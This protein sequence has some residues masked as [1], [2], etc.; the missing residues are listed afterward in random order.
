MTFDYVIEADKEY[1]LTFDYYGATSAPG[2]YGVPFSATT[3]AKAYDAVKS[4]PADYTTLNGSL[5]NKTS[6]TNNAC[7]ILNGNDLLENGGQYLALFHIF[8]EGTELQLKN[9]KISEFTMPSDVLM[10]SYLHN[11][12]MGAEDGDLIFTSGTWNAGS[13]TFDYQIEEGYDYYLSFQFKGHNYAAAQHPSASTVATATTNLNGTVSSAI[14]LGV[15]SS[16]TAWSSVFVPLDGDALL[17]SGGTY[18]AINWV[19]VDPA[20]NYKNFKIAK[21]AKSDNIIPSALKNNEMFFGMEGNRV[22]WYCDV[23]GESYKN[24]TFSTNFE[25]EAG[26]KYAVNFDYKYTGS[27]AGGMWFGSTDTTTASS[28]SLITQIQSVNLSSA[29]DWTN[30]TVF[31]DTT[32]TDLITDTSKYFAFRAYSSWGAPK[33]YFSNLTITE[34]DADSIYPIAGDKFASQMVDGEVVTTYSA[35]T[36][37]DQYDTVGF[38]TDYVLENN[39][40][41]IVAFDYKYNG[42]WFNDSFRAISTGSAWN[43]DRLRAGKMVDILNAGEKVEGWTQAVAGFIAATDETNTNLG[44]A[45][46][47]APNATY[48]LSVKGIKLYENGDVNLDNTIDTSDIALLKKTL[49]G[50]DAEG[51]AFTNIS[52]DEENSTNVLDLVKIKKIL[53]EKDTVAE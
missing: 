21:V 11:T 38:T 6:W 49:I 34:V 41:Y 20:G 22:Y 18:L 45:A 50:A 47:A 24:P 33:L 23:P 9:I 36:G 4:K 19:H 35:T 27:M 5:P 32:K 53:A 39:K 25:I 8:N 17:A 29:D 7:V 3:V 44:F 52:L 37:A 14:K 16:K 26:K 46:M 40:E 13:I 31:F 15:P 42:A 2:G 10:P 43:E 28:E 12:S 30:T 51:A 1:L 48:E